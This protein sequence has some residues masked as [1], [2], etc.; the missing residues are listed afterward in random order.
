MRMAGVV[1]SSC[2]PDLTDQINAITNPMDML[3]LNPIMMYIIAIYRIFLVSQ[4]STFGS[5]ENMIIV[6]LWN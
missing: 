3:K 2:W 5:T 4:I 1:K 6:M